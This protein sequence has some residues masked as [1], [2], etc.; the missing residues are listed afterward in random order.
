MIG[1]TTHIAAFSAG[2]ECS[3]RKKPAIIVIETKSGTSTSAFFHPT[4]D[5]EVTA[6]INRISAAERAV[7]MK[8]KSYQMGSR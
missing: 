6:K 4:V 1:N 7:Q 5:P 2:K 8:S 3:Q